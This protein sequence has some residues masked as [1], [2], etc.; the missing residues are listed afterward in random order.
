MTPNAECDVGPVASSKSLQNLVSEFNLTIIYSPHFCSVIH[1]NCSYDQKR[2][3]DSAV[4]EFVGA[5]DCTYF[6]DTDFSIYHRGMKHEVNNVFVDFYRGFG[7]RSSQG[8]HFT[9]LQLSI[10]LSG[11]QRRLAPR[12]ER[13][14]DNSSQPIGAPLTRSRSAGA[15]VP[16]QPSLCD[17]LNA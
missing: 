6:C 4:A 2:H 1:E 13:Q 11:Q 9:Q 3:M 16:G 15:D 8:V 10:S 12:V 17:L 14:N 7:R 5:L